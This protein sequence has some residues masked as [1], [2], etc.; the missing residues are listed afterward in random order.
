MACPIRMGVSPPSS[1]DIQ[2][3]PMVYGLKWTM[4][5]PTGPQF[6]G[7]HLENCV[8]TMHT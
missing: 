4:V 2:G 1:G 8:C 6:P 3:T 5:G 7:A